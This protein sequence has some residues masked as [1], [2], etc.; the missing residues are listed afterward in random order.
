LLR[1]MKTS[2]AEVLHEGGSTSFMGV[3]LSV[4]ERNK[5]VAQALRVVGQY[6]WGGIG[7]RGGV[8]RDLIGAA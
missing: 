6:R 7:M 1:P 2:A 4:F 3:V 5:P 8:A